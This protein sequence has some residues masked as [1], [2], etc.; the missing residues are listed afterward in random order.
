MQEPLQGSPGR[1]ASMW[2][3]PGVA[4]ARGGVGGLMPEG[5]GPAA[6]I[7]S[8]LLSF[9]MEGLVRVFHEPASLDGL[10]L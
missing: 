5:Q 7:P 9:W 10:F 4:T 6:Q 2:L 1:P 8:C 3:N